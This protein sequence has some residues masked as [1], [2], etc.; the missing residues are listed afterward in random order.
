[1]LVTILVGLAVLSVIVL[2]HELGHFMTAKAA[3]IWVEEFGLGYPP[4]IFGFK[5]GETVYSL[6]AIPFGGF[7]KL[8]G[9]EDPSATRSLASK[10]VAVRLL[11][12]NGGILMNLLLP[13][14]LL[15]AAYIIPHDV[16]IGQVT[17]REVA[18]GSPAQLAGIEPGDVILSIDGKPLNSSGHLSRSTQLNLGREITLNIEHSD[19]SMEEVSLVPR[20]RPPEGE[21]PI[22]ASI[23]TESPAVVSQSFPFWQ[24]I[25]M[26]VTSC[27]EVLV[28]YKN[29]IIGLVTGAV[30]LVMTGPVGIV[31]ITG[32]MAQAGISPVLELAAFI[33]IA[34]AITQLLPIP[35]LDGGRTVFVLLEW[36]R[37]GKRVSPKVEGKIHMVG[38]FLLIS[39]MILITYQDIVRIIAGESLIG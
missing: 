17:V 23:Y 6:N 35:A 4:R 24:A 25:P 28:L 16:V 14:V 32:E 13:L 36:V 19:A 27:I 18:S 39:L 26:G 2:V 30:P 3:G 31:Q 1:M 10:S 22:G 7:N 8:L 34:I 12:L 29:G 37:R 15:S 21:G 9:E 5:R 20:W 38:F 33:S 11:V